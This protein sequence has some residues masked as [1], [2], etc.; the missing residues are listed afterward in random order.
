MTKPEVTNTKVE[1]RVTGLN[2]SI[3]PDRL[4]Q[5][6]AFAF[7]SKDHRRQLVEGRLLK[8]AAHGQIAN[9]VELLAF[10]RVHHE[11]E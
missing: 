4:A 2:L 5:A 10:V 6:I 3:E 11:A 1:S 7:P 9:E 8:G